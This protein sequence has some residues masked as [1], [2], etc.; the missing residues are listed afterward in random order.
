M[1]L[2]YFSSFISHYKNADGAL[3]VYDI[4]D[5]SSFDHIMGWIDEL[6]RNTGNEL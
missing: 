4:S 5:K 6:K 2:T 3:V 1:I